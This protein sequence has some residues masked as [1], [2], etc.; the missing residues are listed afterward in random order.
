MQKGFSY[1]LYNIDDHGEATPYGL[2]QNARSFDVSINGDIIFESF[3]ATHP[4]EIWL[5]GADKK[6]VQVSHFNKAFDT[7]PL[8]V[9]QFITYKSFDGTLVEA[10]RDLLVS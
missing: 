3:N 1:R 7:I 2:N 8:S 6:P 4:A 10:M 9:P 5:S